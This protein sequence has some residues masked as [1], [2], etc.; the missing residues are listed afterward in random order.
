MLYWSTSTTNSQPFSN[1]VTS[2]FTN[3]PGLSAGENFY[4]QND[5]RLTKYSSWVNA[6]RGSLPFQFNFTIESHNRLSLKWSVGDGGKWWEGNTDHGPCSS[7]LPCRYMSSSC[8]HCCLYYLLRSICWLQASR[9]VARW[10]THD[11]SCARQM[12]LFYFRVVVFTQRNNGKGTNDIE[13]HNEVKRGDHHRRPERW[14][15]S[16]LENFECSESLFAKRLCFNV[17]YANLLY[18]ANRYCNCHH[19]QIND[20]FRFETSCTTHKSLK[21]IIICLKGEQLIIYESVPV[22]QSKF[23]PNIIH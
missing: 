16:F 15:V 6:E 8:T 5:L 1:S 9:I 11:L 22:Y 2:Q 3:Q 20:Y 4:W 21:S 23:F 18:I 19:F 13:K 14:P 17:N 7:L 12:L 10:L